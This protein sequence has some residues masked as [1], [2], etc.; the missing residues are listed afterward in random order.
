MSKLFKNMTVA[1][2]GAFLERMDEARA[3]GLP[4]PATDEA[5]IAANDYVVEHG[6]TIAKQFAAMP[7]PVKKIIGK[8][9]ARMIKRL[10]T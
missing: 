7:D 9:A 6:P 8:V 10:E 4:V 2:Q 5:C 3:K 1:E